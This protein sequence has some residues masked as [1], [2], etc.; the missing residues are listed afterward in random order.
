M[1][2]DSRRSDGGEAQPGSCRNQPAFMGTLLT[3]LIEKGDPVRGVEL[4]QAASKLAPNALGL[5]LTLAKGL[6]KANR[7]DAAKKELEELAKLGDKFPAQAEVTKLMQ[8]L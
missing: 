4:L 1:T 3:L 6:I 7:K 5:R 2:Q 8:G